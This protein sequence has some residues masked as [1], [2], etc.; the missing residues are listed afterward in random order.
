MN[1]FTEQLAATRAN[2][3]R[4]EKLFAERP[5]LFEHASLIEV[6]PDHNR[7]FIHASKDRGRDWRAWAKQFGDSWVKEPSPSSW[8]RHWDY[9]GKIGGVDISILQAEQREQPQPLFAEEAAV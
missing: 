8:S 5:E 1:S 4:L 9:S 7:V 6:A 2:L 3:E